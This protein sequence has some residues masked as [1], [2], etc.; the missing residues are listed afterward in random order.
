M[1]T[2]DIVMTFF[3]FICLYKIKNKNNNKNVTGNI[4]W[5]LKKGRNNESQKGVNKANDV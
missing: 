3:C 2:K 5:P 1:K 4:K